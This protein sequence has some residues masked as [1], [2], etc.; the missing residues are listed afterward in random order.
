M[1]V[2]KATTAPLIPTMR[3]ADADRALDF[4]VGVFGF[5]EHAVFR[6]DAGRV[7]HAELTF[8]NGTIMIGPV[9]D[10]P[11]SRFMRQPGAAGGVTTSLYA[12]VT[13]PDAHCARAEAA[14]FEILLPL[15]DHDYGGRDYTV[16]D[17]EGHVWTF[18]TYDPAAT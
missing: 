13:D 11:F 3:Y 6:D 10:T 9:A 8:G 12:I 7:M 1:S 16:R 18:G 14:G 15:T 4:L 17:P 5:A 2:P